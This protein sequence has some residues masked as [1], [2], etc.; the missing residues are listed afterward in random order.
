M[1]HNFLRRLKQLHARLT[2]EAGGSTFK[3]CILLG[4][5]VLYALLGG[6][7]IY[8]CYCIGR[9][10]IKEDTLFWYAAYWLCFGWALLKARPDKP[11]GSGRR[12][13]H[14]HSG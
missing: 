10:F 7:I 1:E 11:V 14:G 8:R 4:V 12:F 9:Y 2:R 6:R 5:R 13:K 3:Y